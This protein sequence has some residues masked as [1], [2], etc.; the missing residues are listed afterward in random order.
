MTQLMALIEKNTFLVKMATIPVTFSYTTVDGKAIA[1]SD[2]VAKSGPVTIPVGLT[3]TTIDVT[4]NSDTIYESNAGNNNLTGGIGNDV[5][6]GG[7]G[8][9]TLIGGVG[10]DFY[11]VDTTTDT[12]T[13]NANE[14]TDGIAS[15]VTYTLVGTNIE[16]LGL[17]GKLLR[18]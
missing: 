4:I 15:G 16:N 14:G 5:F 11:A 2:Y 3:S 12:I 17:I 13:E 9:D 1:G 7:D 8:V 18:S 6:Y 10:D